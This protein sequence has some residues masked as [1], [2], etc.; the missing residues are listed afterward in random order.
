MGLFKKKKKK[1]TEFKNGCI[2]SSRFTNEFYKTYT[3]SFNIYVDGKW[4][5]VC[6]IKEGED[7]FFKLEFSFAEGKKEFQIP[8]NSTPDTIVAAIRAIMKKIATD[9]NNKWNK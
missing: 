6:E 3:D 5:W 1:E 2:V 7:H 4:F 8:I 9:L